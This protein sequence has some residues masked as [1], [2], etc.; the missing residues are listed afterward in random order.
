MHCGIHPTAECIDRHDRTAEERTRPPESLL[1]W[2]GPEQNA[3]RVI[4]V[5]AVSA[6][7]AAYS[8]G[9]FTSP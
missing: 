7:L 4:V 9:H 6:V 8:R 3:R 1:R 2:P 5:K